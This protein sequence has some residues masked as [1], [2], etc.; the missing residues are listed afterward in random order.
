VDNKQIEKAS[1]KVESSLG[2]LLKRDFPYVG[3]GG[4]KLEAA[5]KSFSIRA[6]RK[7]CADIGSSIGGFTDCLVKNNALKV[8]SIDIASEM[9]HP[10]LKN[11]KEKLVLLLGVDARNSI[12]IEE[13]VDLCTLDITFSSLRDVLPNVKS[14]MREDGDIVA[15]IKPIFETEFLNK[16]KLEKKHDPSQLFQILWGIIQWSKKNLFF[17]YKIIKSPELSKRVA[18]EYFIHLRLEESDGIIIDEK[19]IRNIL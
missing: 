8:Y 6:E 17:P 7:I 2:I 10:T 16:Q 5:L 9:L 15:L 4:L 12:P 3:R 11:R 13:K 18:K 1:K 14:I 19:Y